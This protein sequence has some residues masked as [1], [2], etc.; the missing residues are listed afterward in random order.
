[1]PS[2][3]P[4]VSAVSV[5]C[6]FFRG[7]GD[8]SRLAILEKLSTGPM[9]VT[10]LV[11]TTGLTQSNVSNH[12]ACLR[13]CGL[14]VNSSDGRFVWYKLKDDR[15]ADLLALATEITSDAGSGMAE[16]QRYE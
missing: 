16:C 12:L 9:I 15:I 7:L 3:S 10:D 1:M 14:V 6:K 11:Q 5:T 4:K 13:E 8:S 2:M